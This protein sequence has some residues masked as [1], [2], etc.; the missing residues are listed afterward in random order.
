MHAVSYTAQWVAAARALETERDADRLFADPYARDLAAPRGFELV[1]RYAGGGLLSYVAI[2]TRFLDDTIAAVLADSGITQVVFVAA[3]M[4]S[5]AFRLSW[6]TGTVVYEVD[7]GPL[8]DEKRRRLDR[9]R[10]EPAVDRRPVPA[11]LTR[12]WLPALTAAGFDAGRP[13]LW[14]VEGLL[15]FL[16][17]EQAAGLLAT[18]GLVSAPGSQL[19]ADLFS[20]QLLRSPF[21]RNFLELLREDGTPWQFGTDEPEDFLARHGWKV[22]DLRQPGEP[23]A[24]AGRW[25]Y[26]VQPRER[27]GASRQW[28][29]RAEISGA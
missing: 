6:P 14:V 7:H 19:A 21:T 22:Q 25:P 13:T 5:R 2:R 16:T 9:L 1:D 15:F 12:D 23:G 18:L 8:L 29:V 27:R 11:D 17:E 26:Q 3:G 10:A 20:A 24:G 4:D 28:L